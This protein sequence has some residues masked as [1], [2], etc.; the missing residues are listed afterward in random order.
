MVIISLFLLF[1][2]MDAERTTSTSNIDKFCQSIYAFPL[3]FVYCTTIK[4]SRYKMITQ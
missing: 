2:N 3:M 1:E 4:N